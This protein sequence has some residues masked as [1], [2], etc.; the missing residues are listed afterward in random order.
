MAR[1]GLLDVVA[2]RRPDCWEQCARAWIEAE[3]IRALLTTATDA[4]ANRT[5]GAT[6]AGRGARALREV[7]P[8]RR[9]RTRW[10]RSAR[11]RRQRR[12]PC[13]S[14]HRPLLVV[15]HAA[16]YDPEGVRKDLAPDPCELLRASA[17]TRQRPIASTSAVGGQAGTAPGM[18]FR[19]Q[20]PG[21]N[22]TMSLP[23]SLWFAVVF[24]L[25]ADR[26]APS[27]AVECGPGPVP[28]GRPATASDLAQTQRRSPP[29]TSPFPS[30]RR[31]A[32]PGASRCTASPRRRTHP[33]HRAL[34]ALAMARRPRRAGARAAGGDGGDPVPGPARHV[35]R[36]L[37]A[38]AIIVVMGHL[39]RWSH[40]L[41]LLA[42]PRCA[43]PCLR[44][45]DRRPRCGAWS[46]WALACWTAQ[47]ALGGWTSANYAAL[48]RG[49]DFPTGA[50]GGRQP[51][52]VEALRAVARFGVNGEGGVLDGAA[53]TAIQ[54]SH[55]L[56]AVLVADTSRQACRS[57]GGGCAATPRPWAGCPGACS[58]CSASATCTS[59]WPLAVALRTTAWPPCLLFW[60]A[61]PCSRR[62]V[63]RHIPDWRAPCPAVTLATMAAS[64][65]QY[66]N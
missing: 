12:Y 21:G 59:A 31:S 7:R 8:D 18:R 16:G 10:R 34:P 1:C 42:S 45:G 49:T 53:R 46:S 40:H 43:S 27:P 30:V 35:D 4:R 38:D 65:P 14:T 17:A 19:T 29:P 57:P 26:S 48:A 25:T 36:Y 22:P 62:C 37:E 55:R 6:T 24:A 33:H 52:S 11:R 61:W 13:W 39:L 54:L 20:E 28:T 63:R 64:V 60:R 23:A 15:R 56:G 51:T 47:I 41:A 9:R 3:G 2:A 44:R 66:S 32:R 58:G 50:S 5:S